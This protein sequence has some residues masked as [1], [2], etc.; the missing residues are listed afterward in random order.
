M[1]HMASLTMCPC[2]LTHGK[3]HQ[4]WLGWFLKAVPPQ[5]LY[6]HRLLLPLSS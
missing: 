6:Q 2:P 1:P 4:V 3:K 5:C